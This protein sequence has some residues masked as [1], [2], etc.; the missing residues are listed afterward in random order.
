MGTITDDDDPPTL[1]INSP[2]VTEGNTGATANLTFTVTLS[3]VS[4]KQVTVG[5]ALA[6]PD[7]G[8]ATSGTDYAALAAGTLTIAAG[9]TTGTIRVSVTGDTLDEA[10]ET[11]RIALSG[12]TNATLSATAT[13]VG[14][15]TDDDDPPTLSINSPSVTEGNTGA[16]ANLTFTVTLSAASGRQVTAGYMVD[17]TDAGTATSGTDYAALTAGTVT[18]AAGSTTGTI[19]VSVTGDALDEDNETVRITLSNPTNATI[20]T[21]TGVGTI[22]DDDAAPTL[23]INSPSVAE[24]AA[25]ATAN[26]VFTVTLS[27]A[28]GKQVTV[29]YAVDGTDAG[30]ATSGTDYTALTAGTLTFAAGTLTRMITVTVTGDELDEADETVRVTL[31][32][33]ANAGLSTATGV[34]T[35]TDDDGAPSL[36]ISSPSVAE[37]DSGTTANLD[38]AVMLSAASGQ[39]VTVD[40]AVDGTDPGTATSGTDYTALAAGT[41]TFAV[42]DTSE[43]I[44]VTVTGDTQ[45]EPNE[46]VRITL[47]GAANASLSTATGVGTI[48]D[49]DAAPTATLSLN[50]ASITENGGTAQ[51]SATLDRASS[52]ATTVTVAA[53]ANAYTV[54]ASA[55]T[56]TIAAGVT[57]GGNTVTITAVDNHVDAA[58]NTVTVAGTAVNSQGVAAAATGASLTIT[59]DDV[60]GLTVAPTAVTTSEPNGPSP[61]ATFTVRLASEP[62]AAVTVGI[63]VDGGET[64]EASVD[65]TSLR[66]DA[67]ASGSAP[68]QV[69]KWDDPQTVTVTGAEDPDLDGTQTYEITV[70][71]AS[72]QSGGDATYNSDSLVPDVTVSG[73]NLDDEAPT[74]TLELSSATIEEGAAATLTASLDRTVTEATTV[75][76]EVAPGPDAAAADFR[77]SGTT[78]TIPMGETRSAGVTLTAVDNNVDAPDKTATVSGTTSGGQGAANPDPLTLT[79]TDDEAAPVPT[80][81]PADPE[82]WESGAGSRTAVSARLSHASS[83]ATTIT[84]LPL[85]NVYVVVGRATIVI[86]AFQTTSSDRVTIEAVD[87]QEVALER[88]PVVMIRGTASNDQGAGAVRARPLT[89]LDDETASVSLALEPARVAEGG[90]AR[91][92]ATLTRAV[93]A[94]VSVTISAAP[95]DGATEA[96]FALGAERTLTVPAGATASTGSVTITAVDDAVDAPDREVTVTAAV[97]AG[98]RA[99]MPAALTLAIEDDDETPRAT[100]V[101]TPAAIDESGANNSATVSATLSGPSSEPTTIAVSAVGEGFTQTGTTLTIPALGTESAAAVAITAVDDDEQNPDREVVVSGRA[102]NAHGVEQPAD[103]V[104]TI[105]DDDGADAVTEVLLPEAARAMA[106]SRASAVRERLRRAGAAGASELPSLSGLLAQHGPAAQKDEL[107]WK[108]LLPQAS[109]ALPLDADGGSGGVTVWGGGDYRDLDGEARGVSWDGEVASAHLGADRLLANGLRV[110]LAASWSE[111]KF[112]YGYKNRE[113][114]WNLEM[115]SAQPYLGWT[116]A[117]GLELWASAGAGSGDLEIVSGGLRQT[118]DA[119]MWMAAAGARGPLYAA[120][121]GLEIAL[122]GEALYSS[123]EVDGDGGRIRGH[124][125]DVSRLRLALEARRERTLESGALLAPRFELGVRHDGGDG[126]TGAGVE[127]GGGARYAAGRLSVSGGARALVAHSNYDEWGADLALEYAAGADGRGFSFRLEPAWGAAESGTQALWEQGAPGLDGT[128]AAEPELGGRLAAELG[129]G[130]KSPWSRGLLRLTLGGEAGEDADAVGRLTGTVELDAAATLGLELEVR[131]SKSGGA[132]HSLMLKGELRF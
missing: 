23:S 130:M 97:A 31:S 43:T 60:A 44:R 68:N 116:T 50:P 92:S 83:R 2:S 100:L 109:F 32:G 129:Y 69:F 27:A 55:N 18:I 76:V 45:D 67:A 52:A 87:N 19:T 82:I 9:D 71:A 13:G 30:T 41:L 29:G 75:T 123:F 17:A 33:A 65:K 74:V 78:L 35:I 8:T 94:A 89:V 107:E 53:V 117:G 5:Y 37:G 57:T 1:S 66:F 84:V 24:G 62:T 121:S 111:A 77:L 132:E 127:L 10:D 61:T 101:L 15:I 26:L 131:D 102:E 105:R 11:V 64:D 98:V 22:N 72:A 40:Y 96:S 58:D 46:T 54:P 70:S 91:V 103:A 88:D 14:T 104:L 124:T 59:D 113:G 49:D 90:T 106:D 51:V 3:A 95:G 6:S 20:S 115:T 79:V 119:D 16:T 7:G 110:G 36:S 34:G 73:R 47:S 63:A 21:A 114:E 56:I 128:A 38:F 80:L 118:A 39:Q 28:S 12:P 25:G 125:A 93:S 4:G 112:D 81:M 86:P 122:R 126:E 99:R 85:P 42:G 48:T 120:E 108:T